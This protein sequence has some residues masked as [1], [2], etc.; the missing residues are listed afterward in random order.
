[1][2]KSATQPTLTRGSGASRH[3]ASAPTLHGVGGRGP[4][5]TLNTTTTTAPFNLTKSASLA[6]LSK[7]NPYS[8]NAPPIHFKQ[9][10]ARLYQRKQRPGLVG[11]SNRP[12]VEGLNQLYAFKS[13]AA[14]GERPTHTTKLTVVQKRPPPPPPPGKARPTTRPQSA[15]PAYHRDAP[16]PAEQPWAMEQHD[17]FAGLELKTLPNSRPQRPASAAAGG[18]G[19]GDGRSSP[20]VA[21]PKERDAVVKQILGY[22]RQSLS[23][24]RVLTPVFRAMDEDRSGQLDYGEFESAMRRLGI[25]KPSEHIRWVAEF[26]DDDR[27]GTISYNEFVRALN[28]DSETDVGGHKLSLQEQSRE[29]MKKSE[30]AGRSNQASQKHVI[31][32]TDLAAEARLRL[33]DGYESAEERVAREQAE[34]EERIR[35]KEEKSARFQEEQRRRARREL[36]GRLNGRLAAIGSCAALFGRSEA[37]GNEITRDDI[38]AAF[39]SCAVASDDTMHSFLRGLG[40]DLQSSEPLMYGAFV[41]KLLDA[42]GGGSSAAGGPPKEEEG[43]G[44]SG[45][46]P[47][48]L[49]LERKRRRQINRMLVRPTSAGAPRQPTEEAAALKAARPQSAQWGHE[50]IRAQQKSLA[51]LSMEDKHAALRALGQLREKAVGSGNPEHLVESFEAHDTDSSGALDYGEFA[52]AVRQNVPRISRVAVDALCRLMDQDQDG[53]ID[54]REYATTLLAEGSLGQSASALV[55]RHELQHQGGDQGKPGRPTRY[56]ATPARHYGVQAREL[57]QAGPNSAYYATPAERLQQKPL[58][59]R[60][61]YPVVERA[62]AYPPQAQD[63]SFRERRTLTAFEHHR[64]NVAREAKVISERQVE[65][66]RLQEAKLD[67]R[68]NQKLRY[69]ESALEPN[70]NFG[71]ATV[72]T[73]HVI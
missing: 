46:S 56:S 19:G 72:G 53:T 13:T 9:Q 62:A 4:V 63:E 40:V 16:A 43:G 69:E 33:L 60:C 68:F 25:N 50:R 28:E 61:Q 8:P 26:V 67:S 24:K 32:P 17:R 73:T 5:V 31:A 27:S 6:S 22:M 44:A 39:E 54:L 12:H 3:T 49:L 2:L 29:A 51:T 38:V 41:T 15:A 66:E 65:S 30:R 21:E 1:M 37:K 64:S 14:P 55:R 34:M 57:L 48:A 59:A 71:N 10:H 58:M 45:M 70:I 11:A 36:T 18:G 35:L 42:T 47:E 52:I 7:V 23:A 20:I